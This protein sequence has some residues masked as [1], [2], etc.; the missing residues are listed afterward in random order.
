M[1][2]CDTCEYWRAYG[3]REHAEFG[4]CRRHAPTRDVRTVTIW[5]VTL[6]VDGCGDHKLR[7]PA[8]DPALRREL[9][10]QGVIT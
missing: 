10:R 3:I 2:T 1:K 6:K 5:P 4:D 8:F 7:D 9:A